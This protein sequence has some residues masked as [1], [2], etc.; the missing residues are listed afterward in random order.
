MRLTTLRQTSIAAA[1][2]PFLCS[3][4]TSFVLAVTPSLLFEGRVLAA[5]TACTSR[6]L[7][8]LLAPFG[9]RV[10]RPS[11][12][13]RDQLEVTQFVPLMSISQ[14]SSRIVLLFFVSFIWRCLKV[15]TFVSLI[16]S[17]ALG[18][19]GCT[20]AKLLQG[21]SGCLT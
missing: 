13:L 9:G 7:G 15:M 8:L 11:N 6:A 17:S 16:A 4:S 5:G 14:S 21:R 10:F 12:S 18:H 1:L 19:I 20:P 3:A 2:S